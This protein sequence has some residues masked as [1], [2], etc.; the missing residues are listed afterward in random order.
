MNGS[1]YIE[2]QYEPLETDTLVAKIEELPEV[3]LSGRSI[4]EIRVKL[5]HE[6]ALLTQQGHQGL[7]C[8]DL[9]HVRISGP[10]KGLG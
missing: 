3:E 6:I 8:C 2:V 1:V 10:V 5:M 7:D 4:G 9:L